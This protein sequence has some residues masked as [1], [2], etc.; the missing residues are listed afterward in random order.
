M[1][2]CLLKLDGAIWATGDFGEFRL[3]YA[4]IKVNKKKEVLCLS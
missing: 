1:N 3:P 4:T 2:F